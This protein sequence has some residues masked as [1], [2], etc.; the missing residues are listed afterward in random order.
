MAR[1]N[2]FIWNQFCK[3]GE[4]IGDGLH[5]EEPWISK[6][7]K[8]LQ[9]ILLPETKEEKEYKS[10]ARKLRNENINKQIIERLKTDRCKCEAELKQIRSGSKTVICTKCG[11]RY[12]YVSKRV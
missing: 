8:R 4:M 12:K 1:D 5:H 6:E 7:Y 3:L 2:E 10:K 11:S 9:K